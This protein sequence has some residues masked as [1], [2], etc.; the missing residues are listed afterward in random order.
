MCNCLVK[1]KSCLMFVVNSSVL[2]NS[3]N[4]QVYVG[5]RVRRNVIVAPQLSQTVHSACILRCSSGYLT[6]AAYT[7][8]FQFSTD[9]YIIFQGHSLI[10]DLT[11]AS[12]SRFHILDYSR[13]PA[14]VWIVVQYDRLFK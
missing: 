10:K 1:E 2:N 5:K 4:G 12:C 14:C 6:K 13:D 8:S 3:R 9:I 7:N 11:S